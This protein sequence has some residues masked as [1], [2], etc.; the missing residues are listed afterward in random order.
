MSFTQNIV[1]PQ[2]AGMNN[3]KIKVTIFEYFVVFI[4]IPSFDTF[5]I[6]QFFY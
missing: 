1:H 6:G 2:Y 5:N 4:I 3:I